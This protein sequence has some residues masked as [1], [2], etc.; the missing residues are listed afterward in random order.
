MP[1]AISIGFKIGKMLPNNTTFKKI[2]VSTS[3]LQVDSELRYQT[4]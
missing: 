3:Y 4:T 2:E 1:T